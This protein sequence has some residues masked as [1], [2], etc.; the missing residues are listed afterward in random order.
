LRRFQVHVFA[1]FLWLISAAGVWA[2]VLST[3][4]HNAQTRPYATVAVFVFILIAAKKMAHRIARPL[5]MLTEATRRLGAG[6]LS[7]RVDLPHRRHRGGPANELHVLGRSFN[8]MAERIERLVKGQRQLLADV[9]HELRS[10]LARIRVALELLPRT[11][12]NEK[13]LA[14]LE[15]D[16][17]EL[18][19][20]IDDVLTASRLDAA[21]APARLE[22]I[23]VDRLVDRLLERVAEGVD[24]RRVG[25]A[26]EISADPALLRRALGNLIDNATKHGAPPITV[27]LA[28]EDG[29]VAITVADRGPGVPVEERG[30]VFEPFRR[31]D[32]ARSGPGVGLGLTIARRAAEVHGG[33]LT[34]GDGE[35]GF[36]M[37][38]RLPV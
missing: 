30:R 2:L 26:G 15:E 38:L 33:T 4:W 27:A 9:S 34:A 22:V 29:R 13:R 1:G 6:E 28:R 19:R 8:D 23:S 17:G 10:P 21:E 32:P 36:G 31:G 20:L 3:V 18:E 14:G 24:I 12:E 7:T 16:L 37:T 25:E 35:H 11:P 5:E